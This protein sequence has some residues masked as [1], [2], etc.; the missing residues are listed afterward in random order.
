MAEK[1]V[2]KELFEMYSPHTLGLL[3]DSLT[4]L[5]QAQFTPQEAELAIK[6]GFEGGTLDQL[7]EKTGI[8]SAKLKGILETMGDKGTMWIDPGKDDPVY[9]TIG[10]AGPG[11]VETAGWGNVRFP[12][13][14]ESMKALHEFEVDFSTNW[15]PA[16]GGPVAHTWLTPAALPEDAKPEE[17]LA[18]MIRRAGH[19]GVSTC[20]CRLP[21]W[22]ATPG[23][24]CNYPIETCL[25]M[26]EL[27]LWGRERGMSRDITYEET[28][29]IISKCNEEGLV[30]THDPDEFICNCCRDCCVFFVGIHKAGAKTLHPSA[31]VPVFDEME[32][33]GCGVCDER[34]PV[35]AITIDDSATVDLN[36]CLGCGVCFPTCPTESIRFE[37]RLKAA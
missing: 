13:S 34:C 30:H 11:L 6:V 22:I 1:D 14:V 20:S 25:F 32:C 9:R 23:D 28:M 10:L 16:I 24:H 21:H 19:W 8:E 4:K 36:K 7:A 2:Y 17:N 27:A 26:G 29:E 5:L 33:T 18:E 37:R 3:Q 15:L 31:F 35:D 12:S